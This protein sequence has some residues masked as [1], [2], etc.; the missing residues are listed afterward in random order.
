MSMHGGQK[1][2]DA[3]FVLSAIRGGPA[4]GEQGSLLD[5]SPYA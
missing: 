2:A 1:I 4:Q 3:Q 5:P